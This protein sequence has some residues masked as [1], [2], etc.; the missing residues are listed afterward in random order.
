MKPWNIKNLKLKNYPHF[1]AQMGEKKIKALVENPERVASH[2]FHPFLFFEEKYQPFRPSGKPVK[3]RPIRYACRSDSYIYS[4]Y[5]HKLAVEYEKLLE[6]K[7][8]ANSILAYRHIPVNKESDKGKSNIDFAKEVFDKIRELGN[9]VVV[10]AD[11]SSYFDSIDH[12]NLKS[13][14]GR[15]IGQKILPAD[16]YAV[17]KS[18]TAYSDVDYKELCREL[19]FFGEKQTHWGTRDGYLVSRKELPTQLC[20]NVEFRDILKLR[21]AAG[22]P[23]LNT[24][25]ESYGIP[26]GAP[27][28]DVLANSYLIDFD[29]IVLS[30]VESL[31]GFYYRYS[32]D[33][34][35]IM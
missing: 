33:L 10:T 7:G 4:R 17:F 26:Q 13:I 14:W 16:H 32:D 9:C 12:N 18:L 3:T 35:L 15:L 8:L 24:N 5:R 1:D 28:S 6:S 27:L 25:D 19:G 34:L 21:K 11:I 29:S 31:N 30:Y 22:R 23:I 2:P 20:S